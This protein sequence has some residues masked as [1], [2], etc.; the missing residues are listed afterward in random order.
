[1]NE[2]FRFS[3]SRIYS[4][5]AYCVY[6]VE[7]MYINVPERVRYYTWVADKPS[8]S[9]SHP[10]ILYCAVLSPLAQLSLSL[11]LSLSLT[12]RLKF[13]SLAPRE[14]LNLLHFSLKLTRHRIHI[15]T[16]VLY[17]HR[18]TRR[19]SRRCSQQSFS[20]SHAL[21]SL[22]RNPLSLSLSLFVYFGDIDYRLNSEAEPLLLPQPSYPSPF[23]HVSVTSARLSNRSKFPISL[24]LSP[25][26]LRRALFQRPCCLEQPLTIH[27]PTAETE[28]PRRE[29]ERKRHRKR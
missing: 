28:K 12:P 10:P 2:I 24:S 4:F 6:T 9:I 19:F 29:R 5:S 14:D 23:R 11:S 17:T 16:Y 13:L 27:F 7:S 25:C 8:T 21:V 22:P 1:M 18:Y 15:E 3:E 20:L 26:S